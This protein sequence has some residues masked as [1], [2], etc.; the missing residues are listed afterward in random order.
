MFLEETPEQQAPY[1]TSY[2][3]TT[4]QLMTDEVRAGIGAA[5]EGGERCPGTRCAR[6]GPHGWLGVGWPTE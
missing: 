1:G 4:P 5:G 2:T 3:P 6:S